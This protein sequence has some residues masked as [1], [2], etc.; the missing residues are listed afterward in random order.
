M[1]QRDVVIV[2]AGLAGL[3]A[4]Y[5]LRDLDLEVVDAADEVGGRTKSV[6]L[7][8]G[9]WINYGAQYITDDRPHVVALADAVGVELVPYKGFGDYW[10]QLLPS[11]PAELAEVEATI[12]RIEAEQKNPRPAI[13]PE[14]DDQSF[15]D[16]LGPLS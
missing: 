1:K 7:P 16:W 2:G 14:L 6:W 3:S 11:N 4:A 13:L 8:N 10:K 5:Y 9:P 12:Q 15:A